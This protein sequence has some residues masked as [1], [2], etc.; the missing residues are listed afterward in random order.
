MFVSTL[1]CVI[2]DSAFLTPI[3]QAKIHLE[4][5]ITLNWRS[6]EK[7]NAI[8]KKRSRHA[9]PLVFLDNFVPTSKFLS[10]VL[11]HLR[12]TSSNSFHV[13]NL[14]LYPLYGPEKFLYLDTFR[15]LV[16]LTCFIPLVSFDTPLKTSEKI[17]FCNVFRGYRKKVV[18]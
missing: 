3:W 4:F 5:K 9:I 10:K 14:F 1:F 8:A 11:K 16:V 6:T 12:G 18:V 2:I 13:T 17:W 7:P 15:A